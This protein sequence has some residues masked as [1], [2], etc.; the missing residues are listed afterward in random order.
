MTFFADLSH[1]Q[2]VSV[3]NYAAA[4]WR[5]VAL[6]ATQGLTFT[7]PRF[8]ERWRAF[9]Q[10]PGMRRI[11]YHFAEAERS[12]TSQYAFFIRAI[13]MAGGLKPADAIML[14]I[15]DTP[16]IGRSRECVHEFTYYAEAHINVPGLIYT[17]RWFATP[18][19]ITAGWAAP[20]WR[21]LWLS[22]YGPTADDKIALP[23]GWERN[24]VY[25]RQF[26]DTGRAPGVTTPCDLNIILRDWH[27][28][29]VSP[30]PAPE[31]LDMPPT[32]VTAPDRPTYLYYPSS[33]KLIRVYNVAEL[34]ALQ[35]VHA[36]TVGVLTTETLTVTELDA[37]IAF[38]TRAETET[39]R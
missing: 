9:G 18:A 14:D 13:N 6:K 22:D 24:Q 5:H 32:L 10:V 21:R 16:D 37:L 28:P 1:H 4:G 35:A 39:D 38:T 3:A 29:V 19:H 8:V 34:T 27:M 2:T 30:I 33:G 11:A 15:E 31:G 17:G 7:D 25:V 23:D 12:G 36:K 20:S 26:T